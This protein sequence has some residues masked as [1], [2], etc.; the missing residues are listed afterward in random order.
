MVY[1]GKHYINAANTA[2]YNGHTVFNLRGRW[3]VRDGVTLF[4]RV[5]NLLDEDYADRA[6][7]T[8][9][10]PANYRY[11]PAMPRQLYLGVNVD[12]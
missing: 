6:D 7:W 12:L 5:V 10:N 8:L 9:F 1:Q 3:V 4:G 2:K 11:F